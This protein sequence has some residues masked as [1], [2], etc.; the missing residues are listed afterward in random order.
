MELLPTQCG[1][2]FKKFFVEGKDYPTIAEEMKL[3]ISTVRNQ[4]RRAL[5]LLRGRLLPVFIPI[6]FAFRFFVIL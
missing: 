6:F 4:K 2:V 5:L 1:L 3:S